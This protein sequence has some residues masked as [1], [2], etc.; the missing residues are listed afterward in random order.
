V[1]LQRPWRINMR[2]PLPRE[3][4][5]SSSNS[6][7]NAREMGMGTNTRSPNCDVLQLI[8]QTPTRFQHLPPPGVF[9]GSCLAQ[10]R[11]RGAAGTAE[12]F[13]GRGGEQTTAAPASKRVL[14][15]EIGSISWARWDTLNKRYVPR[16]SICCSFKKLISHCYR[17]V[18]IF[19]YPARLQMWNC[20]DLSSIV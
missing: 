5:H 18:L 16:L 20:A 2:L 13:I 3:Q 17:H 14:V 4:R 8:V 9:P 11:G 6:K 19:A 7:A 15:N 1:V 10:A 12:W